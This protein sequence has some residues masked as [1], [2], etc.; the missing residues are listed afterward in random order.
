[1]ED[2]LGKLKRIVEPSRL[3][4]GIL[5]LAAVVR[6]H[7]SFHPLITDEAFNL[8]S[9]DLISSGRG[10]SEYFFRHPPLYILLSS[11]LY[12]LI[13]PYPQVPSLVSAAFSVSSLFPF[14]LIARNLAGEKAAMW[15]AFFLAVMPS[16]VYYGTWIKQDAMLLFFFLWGIYFYLRERYLY[17]GIAIGVAIMV[18]EFALFFFPLSLLITLFFN[19]RNGEG[20]IGFWGQRLR[21]L[22]GWIKMSAISTALSFWWYLFFGT[23]FYLISFQALSGGNIKEFFWHQPWWFYIKNVPY[24][25][26]YP[27]FG[28]FLIGIVNI[29]KSVY[30]SRRPESG[31]I[32]LMWIMVFYLPLSFLTVKAPWYTYLATP[33]M[34]IIA[35]RG[36]VSLTENLK[37]KTAS[38]VYVLII[39]SLAFLL[40]PF[41]NV[42][43]SEKV[44]SVKISDFQTRDRKEVLGDSWGEMVKKKEIWRG[45]I[46][47]IK[48]VGF[49]DF[50]P[51][52][53]Y[54]MGIKEDEM[55][56]LRVREVMSLDK[57]GLLKLAND[58]KIEAILLNKESLS[59]TEQNLKD[60]VSLWGEP[61]HIG[62]FLLFKIMK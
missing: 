4:W 36:V 28:L 50:H 20:S 59:H 41:E 26:S 30:L 18:K 7:Y 25:L 47:G 22:H 14:Y 12:S 52:L 34:A 2:K 43:Y 56:I 24:D 17:A 54:Y 35:A 1:M 62:Q 45:R 58:K 40:F 10:Y 32:L 3:M 51:I 48:R 42:R 49:L 55:V 37:S 15:A 27:V 60:M 61:E 53:L 23:T 39:A 9:I 46:G 38:V 33:P 44:Y 5:V 31:L 57:G 13:G 8:A 11:L 16:S 6:Y 29:V 19:R 21:V